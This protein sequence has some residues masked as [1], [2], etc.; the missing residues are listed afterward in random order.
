MPEGISSFAF[1]PVGLIIDAVSPS[2]LLNYS[3][4]TKTYRFSKEAHKRKKSTFLY[5]YK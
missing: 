5:F 3:K 2:G 4:T 1:E